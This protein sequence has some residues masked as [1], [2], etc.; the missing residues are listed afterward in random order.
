MIDLTPETPRQLALQYLVEHQVVTLATYGEQGVWAA[1]VFYASQEFDL[2][3]LSAGHTR[4]AQNL[5]VNAHIAA[6]IQEDYKDWPA[7]QGIQLEGDVRLL[8]GAER[9]A[10]VSLY[11]A[12]YP[13][14]AQA[15]PQIQ[16]ALT[17]VNWYCLSPDKLY[18]IDN[19]KGL[20]H[21]DE[22]QL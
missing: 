4:H 16:Q 14:I 6:T 2:Y 13:F 22:I 1:A 20:G 11:C 12:R 10:A 9:E 15:E 19:R 21:R 17:K 7:I 5:A 18:F 8:E 3:F